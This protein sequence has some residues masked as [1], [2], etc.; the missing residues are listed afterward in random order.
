MTKVTY[1]LTI[2]RCKIGKKVTKQDIQNIRDRFFIDHNCNLSS[3]PVSCYEPKRNGDL[4]W[5]ACIQ[6]QYIE[7]K[8][9]VYNGWS[10]KLKILK[11]PYDVMNWCGYICKQKIDAVDIKTTYKKVQ[12][13]KKDKAV[14]KAM[15]HILSFY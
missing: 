12:Q 6:G 13:F 4:H 15:P 8:T 5:H 10:L 11:T 1:A 2:A 7:F 14:I 3:F 9:V